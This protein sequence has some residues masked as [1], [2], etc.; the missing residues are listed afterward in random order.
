[1]ATNGLIFLLCLL[2]YVASLGTAAQLPVLISHDLDMLG[3]TPGE[4][5]PASADPCCSEWG[6]CGHETGHCDCALCVDYSAGGSVPAGSLSGSCP[7]IVTRSEW[8]AR[9][10][11][12]VQYISRPVPKVVI[13]HS[14][15]GTC[16]DQASCSAK[17]R[18]F[19]NYHMDSN[20]W[21]DIGYNFLVGNDGNVYE[22]RGWDQVGAHAYGQNH[23]SI[24]ICFIGEFTNQ[25][26]NS[27]AIRAAKNLISCGISLGKISSTYSLYGHRDVGS[28]ACPGNQL[29]D[30]IKTWGRY[31]RKW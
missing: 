25:K 14:T 28:T 9:S 19:Q 2:S 27:A 5:N 13:H 6:W 7:R 10:S 4:C 30:D 16:S 3:A 15:G 24:G 12:W 18:G 29:Y 11:S 17:V 1:M 8:G 21:G 23:V 31:V 26:P 20:G 22:G